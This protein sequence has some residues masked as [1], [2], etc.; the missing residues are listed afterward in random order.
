MKNKSVQNCRFVHHA[1]FRCIMTM[2]NRIFSIEFERGGDW[3][4]AAM[5]CFCMNIF[6]RFAKFEFFLRFFLEDRCF[7]FILCYSHVVYRMS[8]PFENFNGAN[9]CPFFWVH[10]LL[11][12]LLKKVLAVKKVEILEVL[13]VFWHFLNFFRKTIQ[14]NLRFC[15]YQ[16]KRF[17]K[18]LLRNLYRPKFLVKK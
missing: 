12:S 4:R 17:Y 1:K 3:K 11:R 13:T 6:V 16:T 5:L 10:F 14:Q 7:A 9:F 18:F 2:L 8:T 15:V